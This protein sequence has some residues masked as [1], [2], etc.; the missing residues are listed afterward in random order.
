LLYE[1]HNFLDAD[2]RSLG[3]IITRSILGNVFHD[4][5]LSNKHDKMKASGMCE[6]LSLSRADM[7]HVR[8]RR[9]TERETDVGIILEPGSRL[10]DGDV[11]VD[12]KEK[13][14]VVRQLPEKVVSVKINEKKRSRV[15]ELSAAVGHVIGNRHRPISINDNTISFPVMAASE[16][17][18]FRKLFPA[19]GIALEIEDQVFRPIGVTSH[20]HEH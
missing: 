18:V 19:R 4:A 13:F 9:K 2:G 11:L 10:K 5:H 16:L 12:S 17:E 3:V 6:H 8:L 14:I 1:R 7:E 20:T 15:L